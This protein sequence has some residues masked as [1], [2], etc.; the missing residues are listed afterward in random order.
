MTSEKFL[1]F[2]LSPIGHSNEPYQ[3]DETNFKVHKCTIHAMVHVFDPSSPFVL[4]EM[5]IIT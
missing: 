5:K 2:L 4:G 1:D 3:R